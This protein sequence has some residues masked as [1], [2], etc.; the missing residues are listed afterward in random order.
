MATEKSI[1]IR[2]RNTL[3]R[4]GYILTKSRRKDPLAIDYG[5]YT[6][7]DAR[8]NIAAYGSGYNGMMTL[9]EVESWVNDMGK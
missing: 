3:K 1:E 5:L 4:R 8:N 7:S 6:I 9:E 2:L